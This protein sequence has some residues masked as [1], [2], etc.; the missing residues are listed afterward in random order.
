MS[1]VDAP[2]NGTYIKPWTINLAL[3]AD[4]AVPP[5]TD[6][7]PG[8]CPANAFDVRGARSYIIEVEPGTVVGAGGVLE[9]QWGLSGRNFISMGSAYYLSV[10][11]GAPSAPSGWIVYNP[12][13][14]WVKVVTQTAA[15]TSGTPKIY[16]AKRT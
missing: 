3:L 11:A 6:G 2:Q 5:S 1:R 10:P 12:A 8:E 14:Q 4:V 7:A 15:A 16:F 13:Y 9:L